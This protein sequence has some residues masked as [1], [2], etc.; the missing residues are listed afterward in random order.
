MGT[1]PFAGESLRHLI[2]SDIA[3][4]RLVVSQPDKPKGRKLQLLPTPV[5][6]VA[7]EHDLP[8]K[9]PPRARAPEF[10]EELRA[11]A[12]D[13]I[14]VAAYGQILPESILSIPRFGCLNVHGSLLPRHRGAAPIQWAI[15]DGD[16]ET[17]ITIMKMDVGLDTGDI[18]S[19]RATPIDPD[20][21]AQVLHDRLAGARWRAARRIHSSVRL[22]RNQAT[23]A[24]RDRRHLR[25]Q[26]GQR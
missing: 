12:P 6:E 18:V 22:W 5:K 1:S 8:V 24:A 25:A 7:L 19:M 4:I 15:L 14:V 3:D 9:Q 17:G 11:L 20:E 21:N 10:V 16:Q 2:R 26:A 23:A 13:L